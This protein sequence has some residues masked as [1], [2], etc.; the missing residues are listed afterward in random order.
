LELKLKKKDGPLVAVFVAASR[1][2]P[3]SVSRGRIFNTSELP[4]FMYKEGEKIAG[5][6]TYHI[7]GGDCEIVTLN[8]LF[9]N[10]GLASQLIDKVIQKAKAIGCKRVWLITTK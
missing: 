1:G 7:E 3:M 2:S 6:L 9:N 8:S 10:R 4:G 5:L